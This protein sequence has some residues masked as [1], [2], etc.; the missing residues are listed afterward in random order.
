[1]DFFGRI[2]IGIAKEAH[3]RGL[4]IVAGARIY[5]A[6]LRRAVGKLDRDAGADG[7]GIARRSAKGDAQRLVAGK[8]IIAE[9]K[10]GVAVP[11]D[12]K[13]GPAIMIEIDG[14][15]RLRV[16]RYKQA[17]LGRR[18]RMKMTVT[19]TQQQLT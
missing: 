18:N 16:A 8:R 15:E 7:V 11:C 14:R 6:R 9:G 13:I 12:E 4:T 2:R 10:G 17:A 3:R 1:M 5:F 19:V